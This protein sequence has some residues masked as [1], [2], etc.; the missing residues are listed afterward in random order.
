MQK[1]E[2]LPLKYDLFY[3]LVR[4]NNTET[5]MNNDTEKIEAEIAYKKELLAK[6]LDDAET[7]N[8]SMETNQLLPVK[9]R[10]RRLNSRKDLSLHLILPFKK[11]KP[12]K[13]NCST[14]ATLLFFSLALSRSSR[15]RNLLILAITSMPT[16]R[17][18]TIT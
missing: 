15:S 16:L 5:T 8:N 12:R 17:L 11:T 18:F 13:P 6:F 1:M 14:G 4:H 9:R 10:S 3:R 2:S 7:T